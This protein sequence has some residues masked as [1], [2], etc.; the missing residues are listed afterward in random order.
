M[1]ATKGRSELRRDWEIL[2]PKRRPPAWPT[3]ATSTAVQGPLA[4][5]DVR[6]GTLELVVGATQA[7]VLL[8]GKAVRAHFF[9]GRHLLPLEGL[10]GR[11]FLVDCGVTMTL[12]WQR[13]IPLPPG[14]AWTPRPVDASGSLDVRIADPVR[15]AVAV[16]AD[17]AADVTETCRR[18]LAPIVPTLLA[19]RL[20][21][22]GRGGAATDARACVESASP[23]EV[24]PDLARLGLTCD[25]LN[26]DAGFLAELAAA[27]QPLGG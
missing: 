12:P 9:P 4:L 7:A 21:R 14:E 19:V 27:S 11:I 15:F 18:L 16:L 17:G 3:H 25:A 24:E 8:E 10:T 26:L 1:D 20:A 5:R 13:V 23:A 2:D 22:A 6:A